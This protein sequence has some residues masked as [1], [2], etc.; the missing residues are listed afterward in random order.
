MLVGLTG[1]RDIYCIINPNLG[2]GIWLN[3]DQPLNFHLYYA[4]NIH[5]VAPQ[6][7]PKQNVWTKVEVKTIKEDGKV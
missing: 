6:F 4:Y 7:T 3:Q 1:S 5:H 2:P